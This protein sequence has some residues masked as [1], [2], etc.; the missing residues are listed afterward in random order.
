MRS[1]PDLGWNDRGLIEL[2]AEFQPCRAGP[3]EG[4]G[5]MPTATEYEAMIRQY[6]DWDKLRNL[7]QG[8]KNQDTPGWANGKAFEYLV[9]QAF[10]LDGGTVRWPYSVEIEN[11][12]VEQI[13]GFVH[14]GRLSCIVES[15]HTKDRVAI[16]PIA[17]MRNQLL[18]RHSG[19]VGLVFSY[20]GFTE[21]AVILTRY[22]APQAI[23]IWTGDEIEQVMSDKQISVYLE[24]KYQTCV[25]MG[26]PDASIQSRELPQPL[27]HDSGAK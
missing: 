18:R 14:I 9:L 26:M 11:E 13:D 5:D 6:D 1:I 17:K 4:K 19:A 3:T 21:A 16:A 10:F 15:K 27:H 8:V 25:E 24:Y 22:I 2:V 20:A 12:I 7:W 23:L